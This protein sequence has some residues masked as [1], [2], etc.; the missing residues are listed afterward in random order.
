MRGRRT[1]SLKIIMAMTI[2]ILSASSSGVIP[3]P[4]SSTS[5]EVES[6]LMEGPFDEEERKDLPMDYGGPASR[7]SGE[8]AWPMFKQNPQHTGL[9]INAVNDNP[10]RIKWKIDFESHSSQNGPIIGMNNIYFG[11]DSGYSLYSINNSSSI[12]WK[13]EFS[14]YHHPYQQPC[15]DGSNNI[16]FTTNGRTLLSLNTI[17]AF[18][19]STEDM[20]INSPNYHPLTG[21]IS[22]DRYGNLQSFRTE[23]LAG[24]VE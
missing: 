13:Y 15:I 16:Y 6:E 11:P 5:D 18:R 9:N 17:G 19:W 1:F 14:N 21:L 8:A 3:G 10:G 4:S 2:L 20:S 22:W 12:I 23:A 7:S 24:G